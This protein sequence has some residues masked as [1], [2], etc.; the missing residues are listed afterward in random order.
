MNIVI[1]TSTSR[2]VVGKYITHELKKVFP[3]SSI[4]AIDTSA[5]PAKMEYLRFQFKRYKKRGIKGFINTLKERKD[6][7]ICLT[8]WRAHFTE[9][10]EKLINNNSI[11]DYTP[12]H[13]VSSTN[14]KKT[15]ALLKKLK[16]DIIIQNGAGDLLKPNIFNIPSIMSVNMHHGVAP[17]L[18]GASSIFWGVYYGRKDW[19]GVT[20]HKIDAGIDTGPVLKRA[21]VA[22]EYGEHPAKLFAEATITGTR[23]LLE[24]LH[25]IEKNNN[26]ISFLPTKNEESKY[27]SFYKPKHYFALQKNNWHPVK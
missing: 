11:P 17:K 21:E 9:A 23:L 19:V 6:K 2:S 14:G 12:D 27:K 22:F 25:D 7:V 15:E 4:V 1:F 16:P 13:I 3:D 18:R 5:L 20:V 24:A 26:N 8:D 10:F